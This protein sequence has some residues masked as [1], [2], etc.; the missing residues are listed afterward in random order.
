[1]RSDGGRRGVVVDVDVDVV[2]WC[3]DERAR[4]GDDVWVVR[5]RRLVSQTGAVLGDE[6]FDLGARGEDILRH[7]RVH[8]VDDVLDRV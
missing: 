5:V 7:V 8:G 6:R 4:D 1:V 3:G 2:V